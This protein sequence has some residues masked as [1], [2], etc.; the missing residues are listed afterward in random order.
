MQGLL[1]AA[2][3]S[4][5][6]PQMGTQSAGPSLLAASL[7]PIPARSLPVPAFR[8]SVGPNQGTGR[9]PVA[10]GVAIGT[11]VGA[12]AAFALMTGLYVSCSDCEKPAYASMA[13]PALAVG[14]AAGAL[15]GYLIDRL[16]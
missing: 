11:V 5:M 6:Q 10:N 7:A 9:D 12:G 15:V 2:M 16:R 8:R 3:L 13:L 4:L 1:V 14:A